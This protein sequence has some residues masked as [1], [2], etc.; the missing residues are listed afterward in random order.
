M[1]RID[2]YANIIAGSTLCLSRLRIVKK[3]MMSRQTYS[4]LAVD[5]VRGHNLGQGGERDS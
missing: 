2:R 1:S 5:H 3:E 4:N